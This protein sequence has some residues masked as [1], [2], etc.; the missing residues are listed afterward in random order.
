M[1]PKNLPFTQMFERQSELYVRDKALDD[2]LCKPAE[3]KLYASKEG[4]LK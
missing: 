4:A 3:T 2:I 1:P